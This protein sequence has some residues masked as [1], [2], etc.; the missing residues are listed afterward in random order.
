MVCLN[1]IS[2]CYNLEQRLITNITLNKARRIILTMPPSFNQPF[3]LFA[4]KLGNLDPQ[5]AHLAQKT[6]KALAV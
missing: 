3:T 1:L 5:R 4:F 6:S 2:G